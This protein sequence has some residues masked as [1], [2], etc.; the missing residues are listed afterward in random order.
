M[1]IGG[2]LENGSLTTN[3]YLNPSSI[4]MHIFVKEG[5]EREYS[6]RFEHDICLF[7][8]SSLIPEN[9][10]ISPFIA[11]I[12]TLKGVTGTYAPFVVGFD[13]KK[14]ISKVSQYSAFCKGT[15]G[16]I[17]IPLI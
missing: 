6:F 11:T 1:G 12:G 14:L 8:L 13:S 17:V 3:Y 16:I 5:D 9:S 7:D 15:F 4:I 10:K 2:T